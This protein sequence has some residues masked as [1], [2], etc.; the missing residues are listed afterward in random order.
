MSAIVLELLAQLQA[1]A[2]KMDKLDERRKQAAAEKEKKEAALLKAQKKLDEKTAEH[3]GM[4]MERRKFELKL[5]EEK[6]RQQRMKGRAGEVKTPREY[7]AVLAETSALKTSLQNLEES[8]QKSLQTLESTEKD[9][10]ALKESIAV[11]QEEAESATKI[12]DEAVADTEAE[13]AAAKEEE[14]KLMGNLP[15]DVM[16]RYKLIRS[17][18]G[19]TAVVEARNEACT[20]C[21]MRLPPQSYIEI[22]RKN[23]V[24]QCPNCHR[25]LVPS[26]VPDTPNERPYDD[27]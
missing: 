1:V 24:M 6:E 8:L 2:D 16:G 17:R 20:A 3:H 5:K 27:D 12:Y 9:L 19:G 13:I 25:I 18:R 10:L 11:R 4:D 21:F 23:V 14:K 26:T 22:M 15:Q 7:Q